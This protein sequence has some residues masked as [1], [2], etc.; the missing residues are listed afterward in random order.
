MAWFLAVISQVV[1]LDRFHLC[2]R[3]DA[4][5]KGATPG[6]RTLGVHHTLGFRLPCYAHSRTRLLHLFNTA[7]LGRYRMQPSYCFQR[8]TPTH[9]FSD[10]ITSRV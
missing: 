7:L 9:W 3:L 8:A 5:L 4:L 2:L 1:L 10:P 6:L